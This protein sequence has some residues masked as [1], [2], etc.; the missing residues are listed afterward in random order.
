MTASAILSPEIL[1]VKR[2]TGV[3]KITCLENGKFYIGSSVDLR[4]R[5][6]DHYAALSSGSHLNPNMQASWNAHGKDSFKFEVVLICSRSDMLFY[7]QRLIDGMSSV[8]RGFNIALSVT[9][10]MLGRAVSEKTRKAISE[11][12]K[13]KKVSDQ[14][15]A[16][17]SH[18]AKANCKETS[19]SMKSVWASR[20]AEDVAILTGKIAEKTTGKKRS[21]EVLETFKKV[22]SDLWATPAHRAKMIAS[23]K[24][25]KAPVYSDETKEL[26][27]QKAKAF[28][29]SQE[30]I[31]LV[32][33]T[34][35]GRK[36]SDETRAKMIASAIARE[37]KKRV[38][39]AA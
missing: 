11:A 15:R 39:I 13:G 22:S 38:A 7:E 37:A 14:T 21:R 27:R 24:G 25:R 10:P 34:H 28:R 33:R 26:H 36:V 32:K 4:R 20:T 35:L 3:Y 29:N 30:G 18:A 12:N 1:R 6:R 9:A 23:H 17:L 16:R 19:S 31:A 2:E 8:K 5:L